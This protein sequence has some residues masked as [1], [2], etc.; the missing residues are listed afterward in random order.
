MGSPFELHA[1]RAC[2]MVDAVAQTASGL[3]HPKL[4]GGAMNAR[5]QRSPSQTADRS[6]LVVRGSPGLGEEIWAAVTLVKVYM[7]DA[8]SDGAR[9]GRALNQS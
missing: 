9:H 3:R 5:T 6:P 7:A 1:S 4:L 8:D 2:D